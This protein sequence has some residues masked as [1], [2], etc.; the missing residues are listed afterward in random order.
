[1]AVPVAADND[2]I[3][4]DIIETH[5]E[6]IQSLPGGR[7]AKQLAAILTPRPSGRPGLQPEP[8]LNETKT[9]NDAIR[10]EYEIELQSIADADDPLDI[11]DRYVKWTLN[12]YP[13]AQAT[14]QSQLL[15]LLERATK[16]FLTSSLY[17]NDPRYLKLWLHYIRLFSDSPR[18]TFAFLARHGIGDAL[19]LFYEEFAAWL[20]GA[21]RWV[22]AD[23]VFKLGIEKEARPTERLIRKYNQF[24]QRFEA[25]PQ[26]DNEPSS[27]A[28]PTVRPALAAKI[29][30]F[31]SSHRGNDGQAPQQQQNGAAARAANSSRSG[32]PKMAIF[33]D[34]DNAAPPPASTSTNGWDNIGS[35][36]ERKK[37]NTIEARPWAGEKMKAGGRVGTVPKME[38]FK[39]PSLQATS[40]PQ[41]SVQR[42]GDVVNPRTG[43]IERVFVNVEAIYPS[44]DQEFSFE[45]LRA[46]SRGWLHRDWRQPEEPSSGTPLKILSAN[47]RSPRK[48]RSKGSKAQE[49]EDIEN[50]SES[51]QEKVDLNDTSQGSLS[52]HDVSTQSMVGMPGSQTLSQPQSQSQQPRDKKYKIREVKQETQTVKLRLQSPTGKKLKRKNTAEPTMTFHSKAATNEIYDMFNQPLRKSEVTKDD[53]QSGE[54]AEFAEDV[55]DGYS[56]TGDAESTGTGRGFGADSEYGDDTLA[57][58]FDHTESQSQTQ[59]HS[60]PESVSPWSDFTASKH[61]PRLDSRNTSSSKT[62]LSSNKA[63]TKTKLKDKHR[64]AMADDVTEGLASSSQNATQT[65]G[66]GS[67]FDT[68]AIAAI[69]NC[70]FDDMDTKAIAMIAGDVDDEEEDDLEI[71]DPLHALSH[72]ETKGAAEEGGIAEED[73]ET[74]HEDDTRDNL[75]TPVD[76]VF[77]EH[78]EISH[79]PRFIPLPPEDYEPTPVRPY[80]DPALVAQNKLPFMTPIVER[81]ESSLAPSTVFNDP[82]YFTSKT[83]S[84][85]QRTYESPSQVQIDKLLL[86]SPQQQDGTPPSSGKR[87]YEHTGITEEEAASCSPR[88]RKAPGRG[89]PNPNG[90]IPF[91]IAKASPASTKDEESLFKTPAVPDQSPAR[92]ITQSVVRH[93]GPVVADLQCNPCDDVIRQQILTAVYPPLSSYV[94]YHDHSA[95]AL[96]QYS[97]LKS[98][99]DKL[100]KSKA[101]GSPRKSQGSKDAAIKAVPPLL[102]FTGASRV[103]AVKR[104]LGAGAFAPVYLVESYDPNENALA[105]ADDVEDKESSSPKKSMDSTRQPLE[106]LKTETPPGTL[107]WEF[108]IL[109]TVRQR[110]GSAARTMQ[111]IV[112][113]HECHLYRDEAYIVLE[114]S[115]QGTLLDLVNLARNENMKAGKPAEGLDEVLAMWFGVELLRSLEDLHHVGILHGD[116]K[117]DNCLV[118]F[119]GTDVTGPYEPLGGSGW[120]DKGLKLIDFG[121]GIDTRMFKAGA[122]FIADWP[123]CATDCAE[124]RECKPWK[125]QID[126]HGAA[127]VIHSLLFGKY[128][129]TI[130]VGGSL[131]PGQKKEWKLKENL[132]RYWEKEI[133]TEVFGVLLNPATVQDGEEMPIQRNLKQVRMRMEKWLTEEGERGGRDLRG[134]LRKME[135]LVAGNKSA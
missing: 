42:P 70:N 20:E 121:R 52:G 93:K 67:G 119:T 59:T 128:I 51:F 12:S 68:Q 37:E 96:G 3:N 9:L 103:Y 35:I 69:A 130:P 10:Q 19:G 127:G 27:P 60:Q 65:S 5:K 8:T 94:G 41:E 7:S 13:S 115:P 46:M 85:L 107:V 86:S 114:Y 55:D 124:I 22:Q 29:D 1:M 129:E 88:Q 11:Y 71:Q 76:D 48:S 50:L 106:A 87:K 38:I 83:P 63:H 28:L 58:Q 82:D 133:W 122:Q 125:W 36:K 110:L 90:H 6:N 2:L 108:H 80:R 134:A 23:E 53:T 47:G 73:Q 25:R 118:R 117:G 62:S 54:E 79:K 123:S 17:K 31:A 84:R 95:E 99:A 61:V 111:S 89:R 112:L 15:P 66:L 34:A 40:R 104:E 43:R 16:A 32:K 24:Q 26:T 74:V 100:L 14:P 44:N 105:I 120:N 64:H 72:S 113:A 91:P 49:Q 33:S 116:L 109:R 45:E 75:S 97:V 4:F 101:K 102:K 77:T 21:G 30:P 81:T 78:R 126:Y 131:G 57:S 56:T 132:K 39:D 92:S 135:R 18:E 98:Y